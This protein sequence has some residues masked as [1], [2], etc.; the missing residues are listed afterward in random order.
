MFTFDP[1]HSHDTSK[2]VFASVKVDDVTIVTAWF[3]ETGT[4]ET[5]YL[6]A[7]ETTRNFS[8]RV[9]HY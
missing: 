2:L 3:K 8:V 1:M 5:F 7:D 6:F 4:I 9:K